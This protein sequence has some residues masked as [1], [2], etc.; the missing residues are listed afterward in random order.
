MVATVS[1]PSKYV[2]VGCSHMHC[3]L[4]TKTIILFASAELGE[5]GGLEV[6]IENFIRRNNRNTCCVIYIVSGDIQ[7]PRYRVMPGLLGV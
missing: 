5:D 2:E 4:C 1:E 7:L 6:V 3:V